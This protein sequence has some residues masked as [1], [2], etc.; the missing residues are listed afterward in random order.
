MRPRRPGMSGM[1]ARPLRPGCGL[2]GG[3][4]GAVDG[5]PA[6]A[7]P[8]RSAR[9]RIWAGTVTRVRPPFK[10]AQAH[11]QPRLPQASW[12]LT[13]LWA[14]R[15][16]AQ[17]DSGPPLGCRRC[18]A[19][20]WAGCRSSFGAQAPPASVSPTPGHPGQPSAY[21]GLVNATGKVA[22]PPDKLARL[23]AA[24]Y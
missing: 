8:P 2:R 23:G 7:C 14:R 20:L 4:G 5:G 12:V 19:L 22:H 15:K 18:S 3:L 6:S 9:R 24:D 17:G 11:W 1:G 13:P 16:A 21:S 10:G